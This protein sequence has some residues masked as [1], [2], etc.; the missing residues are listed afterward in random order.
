MNEKPRIGFVGVGVVG[1]ALAVSLSRAGY[2]VGAVSS[3]TRTSAE[4]LAGE[5]PDA[6]VAADPQEVA[7]VSDLVFITTPDGAIPQVARMVSWRAGQM[8][9]HCSGADSVDALAFA[10]AQGA[11]VGVLHP[12]QTFATA[13]RALENL[14][15]SYFAVE[16]QGAIRGTLEGMAAALGGQVIAM[17]A[18]H[19]ALYHLSAVM[20]SN[21]LVTIAAVAS[22]LWEAFGIDQ[23]EALNALLP[24]MRGTLHNMEEV[25]VPSGLTGPVARGDGT[26]IRKHLVALSQSAPEFL[27]LYRAL[28]LQTIPVAR[29]KGT[30]SEETA[31]ELRAIVERRFVQ[32]ERLEREPAV[33]HSRG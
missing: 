5:L 16:A 1:R 11:Q 2:A 8:V 33:A 23:K 4:A 13:E 19:K 25:G 27:D 32:M 12:L 20:A 6:K 30:I 14:P 21:Y 3:R 26:T 18:E 28:A 9:A 24:L 7:D 10:R 22:S 15:G 31:E 17:S 29:A